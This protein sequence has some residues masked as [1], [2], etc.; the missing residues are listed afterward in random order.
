MSKVATLGCMIDSFDKIRTII[1][2]F[3]GARIPQSTLNHLCD[4]VAARF[5]PLYG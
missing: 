3:Y 5:G 4:V 1:G 2:L